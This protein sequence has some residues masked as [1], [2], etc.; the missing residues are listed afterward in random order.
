MRCRLGCVLKFKMADHLIRCTIF[1]GD[2]H[3]S[4]NQKFCVNKPVKVLVK[5]SWNS[6]FWQHWTQLCLVLSSAYISTTQII[7]TNLSKNANRS[8]RLF[9]QN[10]WS[11]EKWKPPSY[12]KLKTLH[13]IRWWGELKKFVF[14][15]S[16]LQY[17]LDPL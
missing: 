6:H 15:V 12:S 7:E 11:I 14:L 2:F 5:N 16:T 9:T 3:F 17:V 10:F 4:I 8:R 1:N 13:W